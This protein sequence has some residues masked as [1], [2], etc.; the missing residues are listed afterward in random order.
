MIKGE[1]EQSWLNP[2]SKANASV[3]PLR[4]I[5]GASHIK[6]QIENQRK[7]HWRVQ[8]TD[9]KQNGG[10]PL[11]QVVMPGQIIQPSWTVLTLVLGTQG[12]K[13]T[14]RLPGRQNL[15]LAMGTAAIDNSLAS[16]RRPQN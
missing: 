4:T 1:N 10:V 7:N 8:V 3:L 11:K 15:V 13:P 5:L 9:L 14:A 6:L 16:G 2:V 12:D